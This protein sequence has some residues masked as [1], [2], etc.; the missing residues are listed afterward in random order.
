MVR[1]RDVKEPHEIACDTGGGDDEQ[2]HHRTHV[3]AHVQPVGGRQGDDEAAGVADEESTALGDDL[4][5]DK[6]HISKVKV[7][8]MVVRT[9]I[10]SGR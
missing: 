4:L 8:P 10:T 5:G 7:A 3:R 6:P 2:V 1:L 9:S